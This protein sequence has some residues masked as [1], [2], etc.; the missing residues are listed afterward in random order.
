[1]PPPIHRGRRPKINKLAQLDVAPPIFYFKIA[2]DNSIKSSYEQYMVNA[3]REEF[4]FEGTPLKVVFK[5]NFTN[6][7]YHN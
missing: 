7:P 2:S 1:L 5:K 3:L 4:G 6:T